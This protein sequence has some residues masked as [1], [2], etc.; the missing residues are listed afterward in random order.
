[1][2]PLRPDE[3]G[4]I[5]Q[6]RPLALLGEGGMGRVF[7]AVAPDGRL[8]A[9]KQIHPG[10]AHDAGFRARFAHEV[11]ASR[12]VSGAYTAAVMDADPEADAPWLASVY[13]AGPSLREAVDAA[14]PLPLP[15]LHRLAVGL[16]AALAEVHRAQLIHRDLKP[17][18]VL[19]TRD[20]PRVIDFGIARAAEGS[21]LTGTGA[22]IGSPAFMSPE[23]AASAQLTPASDMFSLGAVL[24][25][26]AT[27]R[28]P[29]T[30]TTAA[31]T[32]YN[33]VHASPELSGVPAE[34]RQI[35]EP[36]LAKD[37]AQRPTPAQLLDFLGPVPPGLSPWPPAVETLI[38]RQEAE[39]RAA[40]SWPVPIP[41][42][43]PRRA[44]RGSR[45]QRRWEPWPSWP[46]GRSSP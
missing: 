43:E 10:F 12:R 44:R 4:P 29:F 16:A 9:V 21:E 11:D 15:A 2:R 18:N 31:Q 30:G 35:A 25:M 33:V 19:L 14:G 7:L 5:G 40:L 24:V 22:I 34:V 27:G 26:A 13:V 1:M 20:G 45:S 32:L 36:C 23:Q 42:A 3:A 8:A 39:V 17:G 28:G 37:P 6:Y 41:P 38:A 46:R